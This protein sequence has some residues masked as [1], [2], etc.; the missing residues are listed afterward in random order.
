MPNNV[1]FKSKTLTRDKESHDIMTKWGHSSRIYSN[2][3]YKNT[4]IIL[5]NPNFWS[6]KQ[7]QQNNSKVLHYS[8]FNNK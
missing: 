7:I 3:K 1:N 6:E 8:T 2:K 5:N 4:N